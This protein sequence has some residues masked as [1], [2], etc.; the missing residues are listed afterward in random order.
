MIGGKR[1]YSTGGGS[2]RRLKY[3]CPTQNPSNEEGL[4]PCV[5]DTKHHPGGDGSSHVKDQLDIHDTQ[6]FTR[7][8]KWKLFEHAQ[9]PSTLG[10]AESFIL[11][12][13]QNTGP[14]K[15]ILTPSEQYP[16]KQC[17]DL[18][19]PG[20]SVFIANNE[21][22]SVEWNISNEKVEFLVYEF[23]PH[24]FAS[25]LSS[26]SSS[27]PKF[28]T[29]FCR[30]FLKGAKSNNNELEEWPFTNPKSY[31]KIHENEDGTIPKA[32]GKIHHSSSVTRTGIW[33]CTKGIMECTEQG[34]E[35]MTIL[36]GKVGRHH[37]AP[38]W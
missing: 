34:D 36:S 4:L 32:Y 7:M 21:P 22:K 24:G 33:K 10:E 29:I 30:S 35:F 38:T 3:F 23:N 18:S 20:D 31:Y 2:Q 37:L 28:G 13:L 8:G 11:V 9:Q 14:V 15:V 12:T 5:T 6:E 27:N 1:S 25:L 16:Y 19:K 26:S 17:H